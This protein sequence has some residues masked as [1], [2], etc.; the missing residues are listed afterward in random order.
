MKDI[1]RCTSIQAMGPIGYLLLQGPVD[2]TPGFRRMTDEAKL[3]ELG[4]EHRIDEYIEN[5]IESIENS[6]Y[7]DN[8]ADSRHYNEDN[9][10]WNRDSIASILGIGTISEAFEY[11]GRWAG[12]SVVLVGD[13]DESGLYNEP[14]PNAVVR[15]DN[16]Q[17]VTMKNSGHP[18]KV[19]P[20]PTNGT[21]ASTS[22]TDTRENAG[23]GDTVKLRR[24]AQPEG[25]DAEFAEFVELEENE[26]T[27]IT[28]G[29]LD[30]FARF[31]GPEWL[32]EQTNGRLSPDMVLQ[33]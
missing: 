8:I 21:N 31:V 33:A 29:L 2:G 28:D 4:L 32:E 1:E 6:S 13:Y 25:S 11:A 30:E 27:D 12:D 26:W 10:E 5:E 24:R 15:L 14:H 7:K 23:P 18:S 3:E 16:G 19:I 17:L 9:E 20:K 22:Y